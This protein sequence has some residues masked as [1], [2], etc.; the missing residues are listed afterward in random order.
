M[1]QPGFSLAG[2]GINFFYKGAIFSVIGMGAGI[3][4]TSVSNGLLAMRLKYDPTYAPSNPPPPI[5]ANASVWSV[6]MGV[7]SNVRY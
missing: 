5:L 7:S 6:H 3:I 1:F 2:R 4:G